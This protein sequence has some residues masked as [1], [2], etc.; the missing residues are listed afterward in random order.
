M[1][2]KDYYQHIRSLGPFPATECFRLAKEA[3]ALDA[4]AASRKI[5]PPA[6]VNVETVEGAASVT[7]S[8]SIKVY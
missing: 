6:L 7:L 2:T 4:T 1:T 3:T 5:P 8:F